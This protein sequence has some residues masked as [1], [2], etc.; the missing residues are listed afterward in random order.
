[1]SSP[2]IR[3]PTTRV[4]ATVAALRETALFNRSDGTSDGTTACM[5]G[6]T[7]VPSTP[8]ARETAPT[9]H[10]LAVPVAASTP[11]SSAHRPMTTC[12]Q[13]S[14]F[15]RSSRSASTPAGVESTSWGR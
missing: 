15:R 13:M 3:G 5:V 7:I 1:M 4:A 11:M 10:R 8:K 12:P 9:F 6:R 14:S 2:A